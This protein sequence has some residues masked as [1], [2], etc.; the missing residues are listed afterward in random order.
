MNGEHGVEVVANKA[1]SCGE[2]YLWST[3]WDGNC[4]VRMQPDGGIVSRYQF[5]TKKVSSLTFGGETC[6]D[7]YVTTAGGENPAENGELSSGSGPA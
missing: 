6:E 7:I 4:L 3:R 1:C 2:G 5:P